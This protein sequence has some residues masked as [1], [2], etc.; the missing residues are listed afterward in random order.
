MKNVLVGLLIL[1]NYGCENHIDI[2]DY[3]IFAGSEIAFIREEDYEVL[4][5]AGWK[6]DQVRGCW[7]I[8]LCNVEQ[9]IT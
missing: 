6:W 8:N 1:S 2:E 9:S 5:D 7:A 3:V 4:M